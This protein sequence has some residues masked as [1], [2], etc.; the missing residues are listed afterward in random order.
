M[1]KAVCVFAGSRTGTSSVYAEAA[2][3]LGRAIAARGCT[4]VYG[5]GSIGLMGVVA[6]AAIAGGATT[7]GVI[8]DELARR[9]V[10]HAGLSELKVV[11][12]MH[13]R[14]AV[15]SDLCDAV[16]ALPGGLGTLD[17]LFEMLTWAQLGIHAKPC[18]LLNVAGY[19]DNLL[20]YLDHTVA[21]G[22]IRAE[23]RSLLVV[24]EEAGTLLETMHAFK[25]PAVEKWRGHDI[26]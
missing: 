20:A 24:G 12:T 14:K 8:P 21:E 2:R 17:E 5:G 15:M 16:I 10:A 19:Y 4:L 3:D 1:I 13:E 6:D 9:E 18:G 26:T 23:H 11:R 22:F 25:M 7:I